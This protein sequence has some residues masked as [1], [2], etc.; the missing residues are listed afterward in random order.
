[1][2]S[3]RAGMG[4]PRDGPKG[5]SDRQDYRRQAAGSPDKGAEVGPGT[6]GMEFVSHTL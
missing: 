3:R 5:P 1:M 2:P 4:P 6:G